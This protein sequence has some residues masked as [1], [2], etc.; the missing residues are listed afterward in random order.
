M[1]SVGTLT[2][3]FFPQGLVVNPRPAAANARHVR[4][5]TPPESRSPKRTIKRSKGG[6]AAPSMPAQPYESS[7]QRSERRRLAQGPSRA[8]ASKATLPKTA[9]VAENRLAGRKRRFSEI[10]GGTRRP[11]KTHRK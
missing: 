8:A 1:A 7:E 11:R 2:A 10:G 5:R 3:P 6:G 4:A 9:V